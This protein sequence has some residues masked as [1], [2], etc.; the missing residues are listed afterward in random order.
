MFGIEHMLSLL[1]STLGTRYLSKRLRYGSMIQ[2]IFGTH[3][4]TDQI[5]VIATIDPTCESFAGV[6]I[7][8]KPPIHFRPFNVSSLIV[9]VALHVY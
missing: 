3:F 2:L 9:T 6:I 5:G 8:K 7:K 4:C 1:H